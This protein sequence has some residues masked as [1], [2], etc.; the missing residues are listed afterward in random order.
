MR[1]QRGY[2]N[3]TANGAV[4]EEAPLLGRSGLTSPQSPTWRQR[5]AAEVSCSWADAVLL[6]C[7]MVTGLLDSASIQVWGAFV[8]MQTGK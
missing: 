3:G 7:Y 5:M 2:G 1:G 6:A 4:D 8:S